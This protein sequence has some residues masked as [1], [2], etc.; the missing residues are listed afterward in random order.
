M[1]L[2]GSGRKYV[3]ST[4]HVIYDVTC[5]NTWTRGGGDDNKDNKLDMTEHQAYKSQIL[6]NILDIYANM[7]HIN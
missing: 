2:Y 7:V 1:C 3:A 6:H 5:G 4:K